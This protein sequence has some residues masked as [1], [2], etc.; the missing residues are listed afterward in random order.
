VRIDDQGDVEVELKGAAPFAEYQIFVGNF[1]LN[2]AFSLPG[3]R[4][5]A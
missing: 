2:G 4:V 3:S 5:P 1:T